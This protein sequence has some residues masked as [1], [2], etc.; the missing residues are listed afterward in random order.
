MATGITYDVNWGPN[1]RMYWGTGV[2]TVAGDG[3]FMV[4][5]VIINTVPTAGGTDR[6]V[7]TTGGA[8]G[9]AVFKAVALAA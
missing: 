3:V 9:T 2:P 8:G 5:D 4:G 6:W 1:N 7:C